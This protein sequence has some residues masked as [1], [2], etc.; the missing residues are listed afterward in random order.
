VV[1]AHC[2][3]NFEISR[4]A[5]R[6]PLSQSRDVN[7]QVIE[8]VCIKGPLQ[9]N[10]LSMDLRQLLFRIVSAEVWRI[11]RAHELVGSQGQLA[12]RCAKLR[13]VE[14]IRLEI[15]PNRLSKS[16]L[17]VFH[18]DRAPRKFLPYVQV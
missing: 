10:N 11:D 13:R 12:E 4:K 15:P 14:I 6:D 7:G 18:F 17:C 5:F 16:G 2:P 9:T 8:L 3:A 1:E